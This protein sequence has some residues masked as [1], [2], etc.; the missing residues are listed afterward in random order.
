MSVKPSSSFSSGNFAVM[1]ASLLKQKGWTSSKEGEGEP[2][3]DGS[4]ELMPSE[5]VKGGGEGEVE[6]DE[7]EKEKVEGWVALTSS[8]KS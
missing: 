5:S 3:C 2:G 8:A 1:P 4:V 7:E 6:V